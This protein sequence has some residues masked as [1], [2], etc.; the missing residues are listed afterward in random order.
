MSATNFFSFRTV[1]VAVAVFTGLGLLALVSCGRDDTGLYQTMKH[2]VTTGDIHGAQRRTLHQSPLERSWD[3]QLP[4]PVLRSWI[5]ES[6]PDIIFYQLEK[7]FEVVAIDTLSGSARWVTPSFPKPAKVPCSA[8]TALLSGQGDQAVY[9]NRAWIV[10]DDTLFSY[11]AAYGQIAWRYDLPFAPSNGPLGIG[12]FNNQRVFFSDWEGR[13]HVITYDDARSYPYELWQMNLRSPVVAPM[14]HTDGLVYAAD[15]SGTVHCFAL[16]RKE[17]WQQ[18]TNA[19]IFGGMATRGRS[20]FVGNDDNKLFS[21]DRLNGNLRGTIFVNGPIRSAPFV[22]DSEPDRVYA[23]IDHPNPA[24][25]GLI[26]VKTQEDAVDVIQVGPNATKKHHEITRM[27][28]AWRI[29]NVSRLVGSTSLH[30]FVT[31]NDPAAQNIIV[32]VNR[33]FGRVDWTWDCS[34]EHT[35]TDKQ[36]AKITNITEYHDANDLN[37][38]IFTADDQGH[39]I[40]Y[41]MFGDKA[42]D[43]HAQAPRAPLKPVTTAKPAA[44]KAEPTDPSATPVAAPAGDVAPA[45]ETAPVEAPIKDAPAADAPAAETSPTETPAADAPPAVQ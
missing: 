15:Q 24:V 1:P 5:S 26:C 39:V 6:L 22:Y 14:I 33:A 41:R 31:G 2:T 40:A 21:F 11:D 44:V 23:F 9:D 20:L 19:A 36:P 4:Y 28:T 37:R 10:S 43:A 34:E 13:V 32:A 25:G 12:P 18:P 30:L 3:L 16:D 29:P 8:S 42:N 27:E 17:I 7:T 38:S 35:R 45:A